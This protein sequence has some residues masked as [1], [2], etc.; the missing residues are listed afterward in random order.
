MCAASISA[1][2]KRCGG[3]P[4]LQSLR[5]W[6]RF[7]A[8][9]NKTISTKQLETIDV[10]IHE[11]PKCAKRKIHRA[12]T[13]SHSSQN[14]GT[15][16]RLA[17][18]EGD[19]R[20]SNKNRFNFI[21][22][23]I[24]WSSCW[25]Y[26]YHECPKV[27]QQSHWNNDTQ[28]ALVMLLPVLRYLERDVKLAIGI[29]EIHGRFSRYPNVDK[30]SDQLRWV[31]DFLSEQGPRFEISRWRDF[32]H[33]ACHCQHEMY[34]KSAQRDSMCH[35]RP[36]DR[37]RH[38]RIIHWWR[39]CE[40]FV[41]SGHW[42]CG[43]QGGH[44]A[45]EIG[46]GN[47][48]G[49]YCIGNSNRKVLSPNGFSVEAIKWREVRTFFS[50]I[51]SLL[52]LKK[53][54]PARDPKQCENKNKM[55]CMCDHSMWALYMWPLYAH[56]I[57][58]HSMCDHSMWTLY[59]GALYMWALY[60]WPLYVS[61]LC[62]TTLCETTLCV[63]SMWEHS[64]CEHSMCEHS[65]CDHSMWDHS[66]CPLYG[67]TLCETT[68]CVHAMWAHSICEHSM[69]EHS[70]WA[71]YVSN[72]WEHSMCDHSMLTL[73]VSTLC[74]TTLCE[75][76]MCD[77][78]MWALYGSTLYVSTLCVTTLC[79]TTLC[80][81]SMC[82]HSM[83]ALY[84]WP[85]YVGTLWE[86]SICEHSMCDQSMW[87]LYMWA[88]YMWALYVWP[89]Y[90]STLCERSMCD[91]S[92]WPLYVGALYMW[93][94]YVWPLYVGALYMWALYV[95]PLYMSTPK[96][97]KITRK[98]EHQFLGRM[99]QNTEKYENYQETSTSVLGPMLQRQKRQK[100]PSFIVKTP[101]KIPRK[102]NM[103]EVEEPKKYE[104]LQTKPVLD[105][106]ESTADT[107]KVRELPRKMNIEEVEDPETMK[108]YRQNPF[109]P[110]A[111]TRKLRKFTDETNMQARN[112]ENSDEIRAQP[113][114]HL[115]LATPAFY[116]YRK[117]PKCYHTV[118][119]KT[120]TGWCILINRL[121]IPPS[122]QGRY[123]SGATMWSTGSTPVMSWSFCGFGMPECSL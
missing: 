41:V 48:A 27:G 53:F 26:K 66:M 17:A 16:R 78:S 122:I 68:L 23:Q 73:Y 12:A 95:W 114:R 60:V 20:W 115:D 120:T 13:G 97:T 25:R 52:R 4:V 100:S 113:V 51:H 58:E 40:R 92:M 56:S 35:V 99:L 24:L 57:Y 119:G 90:V 102:M 18:F 7:Y 59:M 65:M 43:C 104:N 34:G 69:C 101:V 38:M 50:V 47:L 103:E 14:A 70:M 91:H 8:A 85:V 98:N 21:V 49:D 42:N 121:L 77:R 33:M 108:I 96:S 39:W 28:V 110:A 83:G 44:T 79:V 11:Y 30:N 112:H 45:G 72:L 116:T 1:C 71:L 81:H 37:P 19:R 76:S 29:P 87:A 55:Q 36:S 15:S 64:I 106:F 22:K 32:G 88:L 89:L 9:C 31:L 82:D 46:C 10:V 75:H 109:T 62:V 123:D 3:L 80:E 84:V 94:L 86:H 61:T 6:A 107:R 118:W 111:A 2:K 54:I 67:S 63:H 117:N 105:P 93:A 74:V 5:A